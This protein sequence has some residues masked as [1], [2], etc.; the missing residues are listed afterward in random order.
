MNH[1]KKGVLRYAFLFVFESVSSLRCRPSFV[2]RQKKAKTLRSKGER[3][4]LRF[5][6]RQKWFVLT[7]VRSR[8]RLAISKLSQSQP[9]LTSLLCRGGLPLTRVFVRILSV[10]NRFSYRISNI[11]VSEYVLRDTKCLDFKIF[12]P[13]LRGVK[14]PRRKRGG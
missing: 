4:R 6:L 1:K 14:P 11:V 13:V 12:L 5:W 9:T 3:A 7:T 8:L 10:F 2:P